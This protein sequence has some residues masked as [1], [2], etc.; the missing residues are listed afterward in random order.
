MQNNAGIGLGKQIV[1]KFT[2][3]GQILYSKIIS[4]LIIQDGFDHKA[5][6]QSLLLDD[7]YSEIYNNNFIIDLDQFTKDNLKSKNVTKRSNELPVITHFEFQKFLSSTI[8]FHDI[9]INDRSKLLDWILAF[10]IFP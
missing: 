7:K 8:D 2:D 3:E 10:C 1:R 9:N 5:I 6:N 4:E